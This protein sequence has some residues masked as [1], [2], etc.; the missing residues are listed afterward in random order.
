MNRRSLLSATAAGL[1]ALLAGCSSAGS[2]TNDTTT[3]PGTRTD[4]P[5]ETLT[6]TPTDTPTETTKETAT[7]DPATPT[8]TNFRVVDAYCRSESGGVTV[9]FTDGEVQVHGRIEAP[10]GCYTAELAGAT[11]QG[12]ELTVEVRT[13]RTDAEGCVQCLYAI[14]YEAS[15]GVAAGGPE[16]VVVVHDG[17]RVARATR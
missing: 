7:P 12:D 16:T 1:G 3:E 11:V 6:D 8:D 5:T 13:E 4:T 14:E 9:G 15:V 2:A 10:S 17:E